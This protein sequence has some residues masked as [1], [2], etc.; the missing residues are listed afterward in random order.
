MRGVRLSLAV[1]VAVVAGAARF[2]AAQEKHWPCLACH[3]AQISATSYGASAHGNLACTECHLDVPINPHAGKVEPSRP[4]VVA[5]AAKLGAKTKEPV[6]LASCARKD[7]HAQVVAQV[8]ESVHGAAVLGARPDVA[9][10]AAYCLDCHG[11]PHTIAVVS[12]GEGRKLRNAYMCAKCHADPQVI[13][14]YKLNPDVWPTYSES[15]HGRKARLAS[16]GAASCTDCHGG[17]RI[18]KKADP[19]ST[20]NPANVGAT[21][22][23][24]HKGATAAFAKTFRHLPNSR[25]KFVL[26]WVAEHFFAFLTFG[27]IGFVAFHV[28]LDIGAQLRRGLRGK[29]KER[30]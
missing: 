18:F 9:R 19:R 10:A 12:R 13:A 30:T 1:A 29:R 24:C 8:S 15:M 5:L 25:E 11:A 6:A 16:G 20:V 4:E 7:C 21:C 26:G 27:T 28:M 22:G 17:H 23:A 3:D 2:A 14:T